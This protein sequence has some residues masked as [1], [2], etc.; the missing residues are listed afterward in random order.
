MAKKKKKS[1]EECGPD[2]KLLHHIEDLGFYNIEAYYTWCRKNAFEPSYKKSTKQIHAEQ[3]HFDQLKREREFY[4][5][6]DKNPA[7]LIKHLCDGTID[8]SKIERPFWKEFSKAI[9]CSSKGKQSRESLK[10]LLLFVYK[11]TDFLF[12]SIR[13][14]D[15]KYLYVE[16]LIKMNDRRAS[17]IQNL[18]SWKS[19]GHNTKRQFSSLLQH[20]FCKYPVPQFFNSAWFLKE[21]GSDQYR[22]WF[23]H[24]ANGHNIRTVKTPIALSKKMAHL[25]MQA[26]ED[27]SIEHA[28][29][30]GQIHAMN[31]NR[32]LTEEIISSRLGKGF[33]NN[34]F[35]STVIKFFIDNPMLDRKHIGPVIDY[36]F[37]QKYD[38]EEVILAGG[39]TE[40][41][42]APQP[43]FS[44]NHRN[45]EALLRQVAVWHGEL[46]K[47]TPDLNLLFKKVDFDG[48]VMSKGKGESVY[49]YTIKQLLSGRALRDEGQAMRHCVASYAQS[50]VKGKCSI[51]SLEKITKK[52]T[53]KCQTIE[54]DNNKVIVQSRG[55]LNRLP[56]AQEMSIIKKWAELRNLT[57]SRYLPSDV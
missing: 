13:Y 9:T 36:I 47:I 26:P 34:E 42:L 2:N 16:A 41:R 15:Q 10:S 54:V 5:G 35:W 44:M 31:G 29:R 20:L 50:C 43:N 51:W 46:N 38:Q 7:K 12:E 24:V 23:I 52:A 30:W 17:M 27:Y 19:P 6:I 22:D 18:N 25:M 3:T 48:L 11:K 56:I 32:R 49:T 8:S 53:E 37:N 1:T 40:I 57:L 45:P 4:A 55:K 28:V 21:K 33:E 39:D 14:G